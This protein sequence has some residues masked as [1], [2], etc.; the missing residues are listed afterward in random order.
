MHAGVKMSYAPGA[1]YA[2]SNLGYALL[3]ADRRAG[4][5]PA[6][7]RLRQRRDPEA[8]RDVV[9]GL[10]RQR[11]VPPKRLATGY[12]K[13][14]ATTVPEPRPPDGVFDAA[15]GLYTS[16]HDYARYVAFNLAAYPAR[17]EQP[18]TGPLRRST[19]REMHEGQRA[20]RMDDYDAPHRA[21]HTRRDLAAR[22]QLRLRLD[23]GHELQRRAGSAR[24]IRAGLLLDGGAAP[25]TGCRRLRLRHERARAGG[26]T[27]LDADRGGRARQAGRRV[28]HR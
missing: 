5:G 3:G 21:A 4:L 10:G 27:T 14:G 25:E 16:L 6:I 9:V 7:S 28:T 18:E 20:M 23:K 24:R 8:A 1:Q 12:W 15:G 2:Y 22:G 17:D 13:A 19:L 11:L 26:R